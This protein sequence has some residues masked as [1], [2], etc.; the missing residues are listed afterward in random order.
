LDSK[1]VKLPTITPASE[2]EYNSDSEMPPLEDDDEEQ[3]ET[4]PQTDSDLFNIFERLLQLRNQQRNTPSGIIN[5]YDNNRDVQA[6]ILA[7]INE[8]NSDIETV[9]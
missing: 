6:A 2:D 1:E 9:D 8:I 4:T 5:D 3:A 7:S